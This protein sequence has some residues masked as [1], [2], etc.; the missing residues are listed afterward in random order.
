MH[1]KRQYEIK[2]RN[3]SRAKKNATLFCDK[4]TGGL[5]ALL[6]RAVHTKDHILRREIGVITGRLMSSIDDDIDIKMVAA[7]ELGCTNVGEESEEKEDGLTIEEIFDEDEREASDLPKDTAHNEEEDEL[8]RSM[9][10][11]QLTSSLLL[12]KAEVGTWAL[13][14]GWSDGEGITELVQLIMSKNDHAMCIASEVV[15][16]AASTEK[17]RP[18]ILPL[19]ESG[20]LEILMENS[21]KEVRSGAASAIAKLGLADKALSNNEG[22]I[23]GLLQVA[24]ELLEDSADSGGA[25]TKALMEKASKAP[26]ESASSSPATTAAERGIE[27]LSY[28]LTKTQIKEEIAF[29]FKASAKSKHTALERLVELASAPKSGESVISYGLATIFALMAVSTETL[30]KEAFIGKEITADQYE[31]LQALGKTEEEKE[32]AKQNQDIDPPEAVHE[33]IR[34]MANCNVPR[35]MVKLMTNAS[36]HTLEQVVTGM[37]RMAVEETARGVM[38]QQG[39]LSACLKVEQGVSESRTRTVQFHPYLF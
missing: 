16:A 33:R 12:G 3:Q 7:P 34:K 24:V 21:D 17:A 36:E 25:D 15:S 6:S 14:K 28:L 30:R 29:G 27:V 18:L 10:R 9:R 4:E 2:K 39:C 38:V 5:S 23:I 19:L 1:Q 8:T 35:A 26:K 22:E 20:A 13:S 31:E 11:G 37:N 32:N